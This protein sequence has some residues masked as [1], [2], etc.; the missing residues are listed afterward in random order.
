MSWEHRALETEGEA[1]VWA[2]EESLSQWQIKKELT[3]VVLE[4]QAMAYFC[5]IFLALWCCLCWQVDD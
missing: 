5:L 4:V 3:R 2:Q 1:Y